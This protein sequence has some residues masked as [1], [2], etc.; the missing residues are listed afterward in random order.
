MRDAAVE[1]LAKLISDQSVRGSDGG[2]QRRPLEIHLRIEEGWF[3]LF[4]LAVV[5]YSTIWSVQAANWVDHLNV[6]SLITLFGLIVGVAAAKQK[7]F[8]RLAIHG[9][10]LLFGLLFAF[11]QTAGA[12]YGGST[13]ALWQG[14]VHWYQILINN[15]SSDDDSIFLF[16][17][18][19][20]GYILAYTSAWL[21]YRTRSPWLM[22]GANAVVLMINLSNLDGGYFVFLVIFLVAALLLLLRFNLHESIKRWRRQGLRY[23]DELSWDVMQAGAIIS[24]CIL[25][26]SWI[27]PAG[28][29][30]PTVSQIW[31][32]NGNPLLYVQ[33][34]WNRAISLNGL[35]NP[36]NH[37]NFRDTL[38][39]GGNPNL[40]HELVFSYQTNGDG[41]QYLQ[42]LSYDQYTDQGW[43]VSPSDK[44]PLKANQIQPTSAQSR[45][46]EKQTITIVNPPGEQNPYLLGAPDVISMSVPSQVV[47]N[48]TGS[49]VAWMG[50]YGRIP[51]NTQYT[52]TSAVSTADVDSLRQIPMPAES[53]TIASNYDGPTPIGYFDPNLVQ[54]YT[55]VPGNLD[56][57]IKQLATSIT[58]SS[59]TMYDKAVALENYLHTHYQYN[60]DIQRPRDQDGVS[61]FLFNSKNIGFC[62][63]FASAMAV[64]ARELGL[65]ARV[66]AGY[67]NGTVNSKTHLR[68]VFG[69]DAHAWT[70]IYFAGY[71][72]INFEPSATFA[73]FTRPLPSAN[74]GGINADPG[75][76]G[77]GANAN[78]GN[79]Q[80]DIGDPGGLES[81]PSGAIDSGP[82]WG[83][84]ANTTLGGLILL[85]LFGAIV[86]GVWWRRLFRRY[87]LPS[88]IYGRLCLMA[89]WAGVSLKPSLTPYECVEELALAAP[90]EAKTLER[91]GD[92]YVRERWADPE[93]VEHPRRS[94]EIGEMATLWKRLQPR[95]FMHVFK[96][97][98][99]LRWLPARVGDWIGTIVKRRKIR[100]MAEEDDF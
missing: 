31:N 34:T 56:P 35:A 4:L 53:P 57:R 54:I 9:L 43:S 71:G 82:Q 95:L 33:N 89:S 73:S 94:G 91:V 78:N 24:I 75:S 93:S 62:N 61:W 51:A 11:W 70:Q 80:R 39:L 98:H 63:Y 8:P 10:V 60:V 5:V 28:Y 50:T 1:R 3:S 67:T 2:R 30:D 12:F 55:Q 88:Q 77:P 42:L 36:S 86:F 29:A 44:L 72:W 66:V 99:F 40:N 23:S 45:R 52:V 100:R 90:G 18:L 96:H 97:P 65:P 32:F 68:E 69:S 21:V 84:I 49:M 6:L 76:L 15:G 81:G 83:Q 87:S 17:I 38:S 13:T 58:A 48:S 74:T 79:H 64:M 14:F 85:L 59:K 16:L 46:L 22:I 20:L 92:I 26:L 37:G 47:F 19:A 25:I 41:A 27:M 7:R